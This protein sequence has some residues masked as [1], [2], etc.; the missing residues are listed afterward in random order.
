MGSR[1][2]STAAGLVPICGTGCYDELAP[3]TYVGDANRGNGGVIVA[4]PEATL[5]DGVLTGDGDVVSI[6]DTRSSCVRGARLGITLAIGLADGP[7]SLD[8]FLGDGIAIRM[9]RAVVKWGNGLAPYEA[10]FD[11]IHGTQIEITAD[12]V[13]VGARYIRR[14][15]PD[16][17][18]EPAAPT[19]VVSAGVGYAG[20]GRNS[21]G[22]RRSEF[23]YLPEADDT[24]LIVI[25]PFATSFTVVPFGDGSTVLARLRGYGTT[26]SS[27][28]SVTAP[29]TGV[30]NEGQFTIWNGAVFLEIENPNDA[31]LG[32]MIVFGCNP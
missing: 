32:A 27:L 17:E 9:V 12:T 28:Y 5:V 22:A 14:A 30:H 2:V 15:I 31:A 25:P 13:D 29:M 20:G 6:F 23:V 21:N 11:W 4:P 16:S 10:E 24:K 18:E 8:S 19:F 26:D 3:L 1:L 7:A